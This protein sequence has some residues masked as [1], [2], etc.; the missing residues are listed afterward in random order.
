[1]P[2]KNIFFKPKKTKNKIQPLKSINKSS[3]FLAADPNFG[4][5]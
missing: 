1:M 3:H 4:G 5:L 2:Q